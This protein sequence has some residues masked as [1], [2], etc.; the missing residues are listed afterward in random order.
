MDEMTKQE[1]ETRQRRYQ[2]FLKSINCCP[3]C[4]TPLTLIH[5]IDDQQEVIK[6]T[7]QCSE[8]D[9]ETRRVEHSRH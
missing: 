1:I 3:L 8:C 6:E 4:S 5:E 9:V 2:N 7:A